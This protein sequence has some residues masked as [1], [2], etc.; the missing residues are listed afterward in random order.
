MRFFILLSVV[1]HLVASQ[2]SY[3]TCSFN[4]ICVTIQDCPTYKSYSSQPFRN[5]P[6]GLKKLAKSNLCNS[7]K[8]DGA[9]VLSVCCSSPLNYRR[10][11]IQ[12][13]DRIAKGTT[14]KVFEFPW[15]V[16]LYSRTDKFVCGGTL[17]SPRYVLTAAHC[18]NSEKSKIISVRVGENDINQPIDCNVV[19]GELDCAPPPQDINVERIIRHPGHSDRSK[20]NDIALL[21]LERP[22]TL[23]DSVVPICLPNGSPEQRIVDPSFLVVSGW[24]LT[25]NGTSFDVLRYARVP[26]VSLEDCGLKLRGLDA[27]LRLDQSQICAGGVDQIDNCAGDSGGPLQIISN[28]TSRYIQ[29]GVV[30]YGLKSCGVQDEPGVYTNVMYYM[31]WIFQEVDE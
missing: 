18:V 24:G 22:A 7:E 27:T 15:M 10:C 19:D 9:Q 31:K 16:L 28:Q 1:V 6:T 23:G 5:W 11:G 29:Y 30:S 2:I 8:I 25:E 21:R 26:P 20:K 12:A 14:A 4:E 17:V 3:K 13:G